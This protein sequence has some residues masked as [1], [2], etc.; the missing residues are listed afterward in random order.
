MGRCFIHKQIVIDVACGFS[1]INLK[2]RHGT[3]GQDL[4]RNDLLCVCVP[5][6]Q[7][8]DE[9]VAAMTCVL[10]GV[11]MLQCNKESKH[12]GFSVPSLSTVCTALIPGG[13]NRCQSDTRASRA[14][15]CA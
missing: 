13:Q 15:Y 10:V 1:I 11:E 4:Q 5:L 14:G 7:C 8:T 6:M 2:R 3:L 12:M 9:D